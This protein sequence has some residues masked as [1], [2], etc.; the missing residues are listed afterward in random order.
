MIPVI[1]SGGQGKRLWPISTDYTPKQFAMI[2]DEPLQA[3]T[4][5]RLQPLGK[6]W[7]ITT[8]NLRTPTE[9]TN[10]MF[11]IPSSQV[12]YEPMARNTGPAIALL[13]AILTQKNRDR[14]VVG[15]FPA[16]HLIGKPDIFLNAV[17]FAEVW[18]S[19]GKIV[20]LGIKP[21]HASTGYGY[22]EIDKEAD[23]KR[24]GLSIHFAKKFHEKP[25]AEKANEFVN[26]GKHFWNAGIFVFQVSSMMAAIE[27]YMPST[28]RSLRELNANLSNLKEIYE[29]LEPK[30]IDYGVMERTDNVSCIPVDMD[31]SDV[32]SWDEIAR[33]GIQKGSKIQV[34]MD[35]QSNYVHPTA[36][37]KYALIGVENVIVIDSPDGLLVCKKG[38]SEKI[39]TAIDALTKS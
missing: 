1:L 22:I 15:I 26:S 34:Y 25:K 39:K 38:D 24:D 9:N 14:E 4:I 27:E 17:Q 21:S 5:R 8:E 16:D 20:T 6:P 23:E 35:K 18:A 10:E 36:S 2:F 12:V 11:K 32:G 30:S 33:H 19:R 28:F 37:K 13:C 31:W 29:S 7:I 3:K